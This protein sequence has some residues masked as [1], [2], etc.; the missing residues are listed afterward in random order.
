MTIATADDVLAFWR[1]A[2]EQ[3]WFAKSDAFDADIKSRFLPTY[4]A[5]AKG[6]LVGLGGDSRRA[7]WR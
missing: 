2:G 3:R 6:E 4:E 7:R 5:A 1:A